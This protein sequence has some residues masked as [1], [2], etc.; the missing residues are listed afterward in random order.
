MADVS[1]APFETETAAAAFARQYGGPPEDGWSILREQQK[2]QMLR[3][4][5]REV[6]IVPGAYDSRI[7]GWLGGFEDTVCGVVASLI[8]RA[9]EAGQRDA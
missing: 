3:Q 7:L 1:P 2:R 9:H 4:A 6:G 5:C 8:L